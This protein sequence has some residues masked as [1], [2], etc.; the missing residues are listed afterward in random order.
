MEPICRPGPPTVLT[1]EE[2]ESL[3]RYIMNMVDMDFG[4]TREDIMHLPSLLWRNVAENIHFMMVWQDVGGLTDFEP[5]FFSKACHKYHTTYPGRVIT[6]DVI[7]LLVAEAWPQ[8]MQPLN[9]SG[10]R[11]CGIYP[12]NPGEVSDRQLAPSKAGS[13]TEEPYNLSH[14]SSKFTL[15]S[16]TNSQPEE[17]LLPSIFTKEQEAQYQTRYEEG[18]DVYDCSYVT[19]LQ[20]IHPEAARNFSQAKHPSTA[21]PNCQ[22][23]Q[24]SQFQWLHYYPGSEVNSFKHNCV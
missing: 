2:E 6:T 12:I 4:L 15:S 17:K 10:F 11:K 19:W 24:E 22:E 23:K 7:A 18:Y 5:D 1:L 16:S 14:S 3:E 13:S 8:S 20:L 9:I 21:E